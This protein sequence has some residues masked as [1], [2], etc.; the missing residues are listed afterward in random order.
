MRLAVVHCWIA[1]W[2]ALNVLEDLIFEKQKTYKTD[3]IHIF[4]MHSKQ[5]KLNNIKITT[6]IPK[7]LNRVDHRLRMPFYPIIMKYLSYKIRRYKPDEILISSFA[8]AKNIDQFKNA[9]LYLHS[10]MQYIWSHYDEYINKFSWIKKIIYKIVSRYLRKRDIKFTKYSEVRANS[11]YTKDL[12]KKIYDISAKVSYPKVDKDFFEQT[13]IDKPNDYFVFVGRLVNFVRETDK[14]IKLFNKTGKNLILMWSWPDEEYL[15]SIANSNCVFIWWIENKQEKIKIIQKSRWLINLTKESFGIWT[16]EALLLWVPVF[17]Y[18]DWASPELV[19]DKSGI[20]VDHK[21]LKHLESKFQI[22]ES[23]N[24][25]RQYIS[26]NI[27]KK[28][29]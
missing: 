1:Q 5:A 23:T 29:R 8:I 12:A 17:G 4:T 3:K 28:I 27:K 19:D 21:E 2:W 16:A 20:L 7:R 18:N 11:N 9:K 10:P 25:D 26:E 6:A 14:I 22:F 13:I 15:K 24:R